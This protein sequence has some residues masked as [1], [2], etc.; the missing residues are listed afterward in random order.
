[1][2][3]FE[4]PIHN[5]P[6]DHYKYRAEA[7]EPNRHDREKRSEPPATRFRRLALLT[8][9]LQQIYKSFSLFETTSKEGLTAAE[10][11]ALRNNLSF[12]LDSL[13]VLKREDHSQDPHFL[14]QLSMLWRATL[15][16]A[17]RLKKNSPSA[18]LFAKLI[19][20]LH[21]Y[22]PAQ[23]HALGYYLQESAGLKWLP[24]PYMELVFQIHLL[25]QTEGELS[26]LGRWTT[27]IQN[28]QETF[29]P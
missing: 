9:L 25:Y 27:L 6:Q 18:A 14:N 5:R 7:I 23:E 15:E 12:L 8:Y 2:D 28:I 16:D 19:E 21:N 20:E 3:S 4:P 1:M 24:F 10:E 26:P 11:Q 13:E 22:P 17:A 29:Q